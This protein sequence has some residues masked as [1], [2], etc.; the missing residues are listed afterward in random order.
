MAESPPAGYN[1]T[2]DECGASFGVM[3]DL[4]KHYRQD[5]PES[6]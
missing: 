4:T 1:Y 3:E 5:H 2:C 6:M